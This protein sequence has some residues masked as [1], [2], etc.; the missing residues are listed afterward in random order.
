MDAISDL[1]SL[2][3]GEGTDGSQPYTKPVRTAFQSLMRAGSVSVSNHVAMRHTPRLVERFAAIRPG[4]SAFKVAAGATVYK[5]NNQ[6]L[7]ADE[8]SLCI[9]ANFQSNYIHP[10][11]HRNLTAREAARLM[12]FPDRYC[13]KGKRTLMSK[14]FLAKYGRLCRRRILSQYNQIGNAVP[15][16][17]ARALGESSIAL[18]TGTDLNTVLVA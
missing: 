9:T 17:L 8:P 4:Q 6:R 1:P 10:T 12:T 18:A 2:K 5:S 14:K 13:F 11:E 15:P 7:V 3:A 16:L